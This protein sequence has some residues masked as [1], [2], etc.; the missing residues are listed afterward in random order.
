MIC[1]MK[2]FVTIISLLAAVCGATSCLDEVLYN[3]YSTDTYFTSIERLDMAVMG[4]YPSLQANAVYGLNFF[5]AYDSDTDI[6]FAQGITVPSNNFVRNIGHYYITSSESSIENTWSTLYAGIK[7]A[8][9]ILANADEVPCSSDEEREQVEALVGEAKF[10][11]ALM[12]FELVRFW[13]DVPLVLEPQEV[14]DDMQVERTDRELVY[15]RI[16]GDLE[17][18]VKT[19]PYY[20]ERVTFVYRAHKT[21]AMGLLARVN[22][23]R[24][25]YSLRQSGQMQRPE[26]YMDYY[27]DVLK[28]TEQLISSDKHKLNPDYEQIFR[29]Q[30]QYVT[31][32]QENVYEVDMYFLSGVLN[33]G[34]IGY[35]N[36]PQTARGVY[37][38][39]QNRIKTHH[40]FYMM[41]DDGDLRRDVSVG[42]FTT[43]ETGEQRVIR[44][45]LSMNYGVGKWRRQW[46]TSDQHNGTGTSINYVVMRYSDVLLMR[47]EA[48]NEVND[49]P[50]D[51]ALELVNQVRRRGYG[52]PAMTAVTGTDDE[53]GYVDKTLADFSGHDDFLKFIQDERA[54][55]LAF[56]GAIRRTDLIRW[57]ILA[58]KIRETHEFVEAHKAG[59]GAAEVYFNNS[60]SFV[61]YNYFEHG[62]HELYP[63]PARERRENPKLTQNPGY[64]M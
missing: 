53:T 33:G 56:E 41:F 1:F 43:S 20:D 61:A 2:R 59:T 40:G 57:N 27:E 62:Q 24:A 49:G 46:Q 25:G 5:A 16:I 48:L 15:D 26:N 14:G 34:N 38:A 47:A 63:I 51:E 21:A 17:D 45:E 18:A 37:N 31:D 4:I 11:R 42:N 19:L 52:L 58:D 13:G 50:T 29:D 55:E 64:S 54:R 28:W 60:F 3:Q 12:Y 8:N 6:Q 23:Y 36:A 44:P 32:S 10:L 35:Y 30:C 7:D 39:T 9:V 22:L